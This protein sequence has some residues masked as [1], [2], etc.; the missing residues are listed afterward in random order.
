MA[1]CGEGRAPVA[2]RAPSWAPRCLRHRRRAAP[3]FQAAFSQ[4]HERRLPGS[5]RGQSGGV[6]CCAASARDQNQ[7]FWVPSRCLKAVC[8]L[9]LSGHL[10]QSL[11]CAGHR[12]NIPCLGRKGFGEELVEK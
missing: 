7:A 8:V 9:W 6:L 3:A 5:Q 11:P 10:H 12:G 1:R 2:A 4:Q